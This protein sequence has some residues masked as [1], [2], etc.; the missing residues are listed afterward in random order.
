MWISA[1]EQMS[2]GATGLIEWEKRIVLA[3][4]DAILSHFLC[5]NLLGECLNHMSYMN[6]KE[7]WESWIKC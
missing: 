1:N 3:R 4:R 2:H 7:I 6:D 5:I